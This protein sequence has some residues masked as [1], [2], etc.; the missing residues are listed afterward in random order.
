MRYFSLFLMSLLSFLHLGAHAQL[1]DIQRIEPP[2]WWVGMQNPELQLLVHGKDLAQATVSVSYPGVR[3]GETVRTDNPNYVFLTLHLAPGTKPG[4]VPLVFGQGKQSRTVNYEVRAKSPAQGRGQ[5]FDQS[6]LIY[7]L[8]PDRFA[9]GDPTNDY[10]AG[11]LEKPDRKAPFGRHGGDLQGVIG[12]LDYLQD[13]GATALWLN[14]V[15]E[16]DMPASSYHGYAITDFYAVDRRFGGNDAYLRL[17]EQAHARG[18]KVVQDMVANHIGSSHWWM[19]DLPAQDWVHQFPAFT[20]SNYRLAVISDP[21]ASQADSAQMTNGWF[22]TTMPDLN[23]NNRLLA[24]YLVQNSLWWIEYAGIDGIRMDTYPYPDKDFMAHWTREVLREY[25]RFNIVG[26]VWIHSAAIT[27]YWLKNTFNRDGY[28]STLPSVTDFPVFEA[29]TRAFNEPTGWAD[30][31]S[32]LYHVLAED[33]VYEK[34]ENNVIF[35]DNHD[36]TRYFTSVRENLGSFKLGLA[37]LLTTRGIPQVYYGTEILMTGD[38]GFH[39]G[40]RKDFPGG[41][42]GDATDAFRPEG[43]TPAQNEAFN[44]LRTLANWRKRTPVV[45][46]GKLT[47]FLPENETY[48][49]FRHD[50][51]ACVMVAL[52]NSD[53]PK[54][55]DTKRFAEVM[56]G[57]ATARNVLTGEQL[58]QLGTLALPAKSATVLELGK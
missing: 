16:N 38:G 6:D 40:V 36:V 44:Y 14:P 45:H 46:H 5:G 19:K 32:R 30:G 8:M 34:P 28:Q 42:P 52:N 33:F 17:I 12:K 21:H 39:P 20:R 49:Y 57:Y 31:L 55:L 35:L 54:T 9:N 11:M 13:L 25:P 41:W 58:T 18:L 48:V 4:L 37:F 2:F 7:L 23:Q 53:Q 22:D 1:P 47:H 10:V 50:G 43:R 24:R 29:A 51:Q 27:A 26:E 56:A 3:L 15:L